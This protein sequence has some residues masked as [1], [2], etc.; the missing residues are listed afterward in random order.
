MIE[1]A[2][3]ETTYTSAN[4]SHTNTVKVLG[5]LEHTNLEDEIRTII[6]EELSLNK[7]SASPK[8]Q[9]K[10]E[11]LSEK[12][13][14]AKELEKQKKSLDKLQRKLEK[15]LGE[16]T[17]LKREVNKSNENSSEQISDLTKAEAVKKEQL[18]GINEELKQF[19]NTSLSDLKNLT[20]EQTGNIQ[21]FSRDP[22]K[23]ML[24]K[25]FK[26]FAKG[27]GVLALATV[28]FAAVH[29]IITELMKPGRFL[30][31]RFKR[32]AQKEI[33][34]FNSREEVAELRQG[35]R[36]VTITTMPFLKGAELRG[37][38]SGNLYNPTAIPMNRLD[39]RRVIPP[40]VSTQ[41]SS[42]ANK[43]FNR[44]GR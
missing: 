33:L 29:L 44:R 7:S 42:R 28:I 40:I 30:D 4:P 38:I 34:L 15:D 36:T 21:S 11:F 3:L 25:F 35:F 10:E 24:T 31:R 9:E 13:K 6:E 14:L 20:K 5:Q 8:K 17:Q 23:F 19:D 2:L 18:K 22:F 26:K 1:F 41:N 16:I 32:M 37:Q 27:A 43:F 12:S 39:S